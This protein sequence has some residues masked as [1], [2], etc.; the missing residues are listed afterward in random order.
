VAKTVGELTCAQ[1]SDLNANHLF[2]DW[3]EKA[4]IPRLSEVLQAYAHKLENWEIEIKSDTPEN[5]ETVCPQLISAIERFGIAEQVV[6]TSFNPLALEIVRR[7][8]PG[9]RRAFISHYDQPEHL[10]TALRL[11]CYRACIPLHH[12][13]KAIVQAAHAAGLNV[14]GWL[15]D[16]EEMIETLLD[17]DVDAITT[18]RPS[19]ALAFLRQRGII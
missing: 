11:G 2:P 19:L 1:L 15:G 6:V 17:W 5:L 13:Q 14:T 16:T 9:L 8:S 7:L 4:Y 10:Q 3:A 18:N 12:S